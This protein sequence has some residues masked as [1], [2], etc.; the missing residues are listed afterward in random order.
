[1]EIANKRIQEALS[2]TKLKQYIER[3]KEIHEEVFGSPNQKIGNFTKQAKLT[4]WSG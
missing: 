3:L 2:Q 1:V 4:G